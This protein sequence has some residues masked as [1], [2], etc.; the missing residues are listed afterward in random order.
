[1][2]IHILNPMFDDQA[3]TDLLD[4]T[5]NI[6]DAGKSD[7]LL[8]I[9]GKGGKRES[10]GLTSRGRLSDNRRKLSENSIVAFQR[11][12]WL[13]YGEYAGGFQNF[14]RDNELDLEDEVDLKIKELKSLGNHDTN[15]GDGWGHIGKG[16]ENL[17]A[18]LVKFHKYKM[19]KSMTMY[20]QE[21]VFITKIMKTLVVI[22]ATLI[23]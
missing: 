20:L 1:M 11:K 19:I 13:K 12:K 18:P 5:D 4:L 22:Y 3:Y 10:F 6:D 9:V 8:G 16:S 17:N 21:R 23:L 2:Q 14:D 7:N 15:E